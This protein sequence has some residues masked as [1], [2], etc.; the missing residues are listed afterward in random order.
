MDQPGFLMQ[1]LSRPLPIQ[2]EF[3]GHQQK[4]SCI[5]RVSHLKNKYGLRPFNGV[6]GEMAYFYK[7]I[8]NLGR[9]VSSS[10]L[11]ALLPLQASRA[12]IASLRFCFDLAV[13]LAAKFMDRSKSSFIAIWI[14]TS[15][16]CEINSQSGKKIICKH[17]VKHVLIWSILHNILYART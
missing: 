12:M 1:V 14:S 13:I 8:W 15:M 2:V 7:F 4:D 10:Y 3:V 9:F 5:G 6:G 11:C 17:L 16:I